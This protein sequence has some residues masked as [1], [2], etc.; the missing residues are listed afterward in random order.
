MTRHPT[1]RYCADARAVAAL[2]RDG[3]G[4]GH[5]LDCGCFRDTKPIRTQNAITRMINRIQNWK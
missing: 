3:I 2:K 5:D 1:N 4:W